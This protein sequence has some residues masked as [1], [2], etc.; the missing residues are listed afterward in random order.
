M[1]KISENLAIKEIWEILEI[2]AMMKILEILA[3]K[4]IREI[5]EIWTII[6]ILEIPEIRKSEKF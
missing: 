2:E 6:N 1:M 4:E 5:V 3:S